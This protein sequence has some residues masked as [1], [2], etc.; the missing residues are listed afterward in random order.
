MAIEIVWEALEATAPN[1]APEIIGRR[2]SA[3][4]NEVTLHRN[5]LLRFLEE[6]DGDM[7]VADL[8]EALK[9]YCHGD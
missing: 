5:A 6:I 1:R 4:K 7:T 8:C 2:A 3:T 9:D